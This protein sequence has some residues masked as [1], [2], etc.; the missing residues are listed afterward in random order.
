MG[1]I[2]GIITKCSFS[3]DR[4]PDPQTHPETDLQTDLET[5]RLSGAQVEVPPVIKK[6]RL[7]NK[8]KLGWRKNR[9]LLESSIQ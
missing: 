4:H 3:K 9:M 2:E 1:G 6:T 5:H 7:D 8:I